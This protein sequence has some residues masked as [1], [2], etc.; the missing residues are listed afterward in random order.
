M[1]EENLVRVER[2]MVTIMDIDAL[3]AIV[4]GLPLTRINADASWPSASSARHA[5]AMPA[6]AGASS[7]A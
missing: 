6:A 5:P 1:R 4:R 2:Q 7:W 3:R